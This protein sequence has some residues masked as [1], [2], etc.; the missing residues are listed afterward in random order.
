MLY[1][2][3]PYPSFEEIKKAINP[4]EEKTA[5]KTETPSDAYNFS[6]AERVAMARIDALNAE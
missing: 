1:T 3:K 6:Q 2:N 4:K 5:D